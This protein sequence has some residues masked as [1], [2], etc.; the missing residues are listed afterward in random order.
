MDTR[1]RRKAS[2]V[3]SGK[4]YSQSLEALINDVNMEYDP[5]SDLDKLNAPVGCF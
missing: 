1:L 4:Y 2:D 5:Q 3:V